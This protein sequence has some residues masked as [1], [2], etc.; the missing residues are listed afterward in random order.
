MRSYEGRF[1]YSVCNQLRPIGWPLSRLTPLQFPRSPIRVI[2][3]LISLY[4][5]TIIFT[6]S[7]AIIMGG[8]GSFLQV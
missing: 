3:D 2:L 4:V 8:M 5:K 6:L 1:V 7:A